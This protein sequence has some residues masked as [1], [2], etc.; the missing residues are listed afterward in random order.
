VLTRETL[1]YLVKNIEVISIT[2]YFE[3]A[4]EAGTCIIDGDGGR[5]YIR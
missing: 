3:A 5:C 1:A 2:Y 4:S